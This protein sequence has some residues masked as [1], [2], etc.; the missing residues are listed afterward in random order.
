[1]IFWRRFEDCACKMPRLLQVRS[2]RGAKIP[3]FSLQAK[4]TNLIEE[5]DIG[6][7]RRDLMPFEEHKKKLGAS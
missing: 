3:L 7:R 2:V 4:S 6:I 5:L 1:M